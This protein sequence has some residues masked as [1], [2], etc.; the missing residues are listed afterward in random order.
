MHAMFLTLAVLVS[1]IGQVQY[2]AYALNG[3]AFT[4]SSAIV[5]FLLAPV[6]SYM[7][8]KGISVDVVYIATSLNAF[9]VLILS[10]YFLSESVRPGQ[11]MACLTV[12]AGVFVYSL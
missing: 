4:F 6:F 1:S 7:S 11:F 9:I 3:G 10:K 5:F 12:A 8:L 2:K